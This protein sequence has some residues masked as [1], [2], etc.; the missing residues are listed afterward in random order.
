MQQ[1]SSQAQSEERDGVVAVGEK[2]GLQ[3]SN[4]QVVRKWSIYEEEL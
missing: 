2:S 3:S 4:R 1:L